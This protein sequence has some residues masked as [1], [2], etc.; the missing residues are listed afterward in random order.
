MADIKTKNKQEYTIR[1]FDRAKV[2][3]KNLKEN[4]VNL[5][6]KTKENY[7]KNE[8]S[9]QEYAENKMNNAISETMYYMP[10]AMRKGKKNF[11]KTKENIVKSK[12][13]IRKLQNG[14]QNIKTKGKMTVEKA[15]KNIKKFQ[16]TVKATKNTVK[17]TKSTAKATKKVA[18]E[19]M[20]MAQ[21]TVKLTRKAI[22]NT[23]KATKVAIKT[24]IKIIKAIIEAT[25]ALVSAI[26]AGGWVAVV[27]VVVICLIAM[28]CSSVF[29]IF[30]ANEK[31]DGEMTI[32]TVMLELNTEFSK[33][34]EQKKEQH[35]NADYDIK[36]ARANWQDVIAVY[37]VIISNGDYEVDVMTMDKDRAK[38]LKKVFWD[39]NEFN[40]TVDKRLEKVKVS[41]GRGGERQ[42]E[43]VKETLHLTVRVKSIEEISNQYNFNQAQREQL[44]ELMNK[45]YANNW[46]N[47]IYGVGNGDIVKVAISQIGNIGRRTLLVLVWF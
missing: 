46:S 26:I 8:S 17:T 7:E 2:M 22:K 10:T 20:K 15:K 18:K 36:Y 34:I 35:P 27:I 28:I 42:I 11:D 32:N 38:T 16:N 14:V 1:K 24:T 19:S 6:E 41:D 12:I 9:E 25:K 33:K 40:E 3:G 44:D 29:G 30:F 31:K 43:V 23:V 45:K 4:V 47:L 39:M 5:K 21:R 13:K 37:T